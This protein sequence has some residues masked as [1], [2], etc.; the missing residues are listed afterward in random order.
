[1]RRKIFVVA[2]LL[3]VSCL[4]PACQHEKAAPAALYSDYIRQHIKEAEQI[5]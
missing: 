4:N 3:C 1:M 2:G 5:K